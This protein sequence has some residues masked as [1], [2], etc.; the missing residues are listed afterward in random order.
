MTSVFHHSDV[1]D[2][3][4]SRWDA[5]WKLAALLIAAFGTAALDHL[6]TSA[7]ALI[8]GL[9]S[10]CLARLPGRW[11]RGRLGLFCIAALPFVLILPFTLDPNGPGWDLGPVH[12]SVHGISAG[13]AVFCR[14]LA[15]GCL[16]LILL[17]TAPFH[18]T[19]AAAHRL[20]MPGLLVLL[21]GLAYRYAFLLGDEYRRIRIALRSRGFETL[22]NR[23]GYRTLSFTTGAILVRG[24]DRAERVAEAMRC[25]GFDGRFRTTIAFRTTAA[26]FISWLLVIVAMSALI[27]WDRGTNT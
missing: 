22:A 13:L 19:L 5:R 8:G 18:H 16:A 7:V 21:V 25:R 24:G 4:L 26:D 1:P 12:V 23:H 14:C 27:I 10:L 17:G 6:A 20:K 9:A 3:P 2:S 15:I 11:V